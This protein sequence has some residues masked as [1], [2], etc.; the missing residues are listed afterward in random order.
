MT[1]VPPCKISF[2]NWLFLNVHES[3][4]Y[5]IQLSIFILSDSAL[6]GF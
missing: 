3:D 1:F 4:K 6:D 2:I 5:F